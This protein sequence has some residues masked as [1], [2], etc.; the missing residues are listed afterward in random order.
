MVNKKIPVLLVFLLLASTFLS[1]CGAFTNI[2]STGVSGGI[3]G[4]FEA[5]NEIGAFPFTVPEGSQSLDFSLGIQVEEGAVVWRLKT[6]AGVQVMGGQLL[7][8]DSIAEK[9]SFGGLPG[10]WLLEMEYRQA[11]GAY[12]M[13][14][15]AR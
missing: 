3:E 10:E 4:D 5:V 8:G 2:Q 12:S 9:R 6:P 1:A 11:K 15:T 7:A 13:E 14:W